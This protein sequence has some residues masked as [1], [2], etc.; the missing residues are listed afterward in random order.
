MEDA[1]AFV[2]VAR[3]IRPVGIKG[4]LRVMPYTRDPEEL[5]KYKSLYFIHSD[6]P[7]HKLKILNIRISS[8]YAT[9]KVEGLDSIEEAESWRGRELYVQRKQLNKPPIDEYFIRDLI[10]IE[11]YGE[12]GI[13]IGRLKDVMEFS[14]H[15]I[16]QIE[17]QTGELLI[18]AISDVVLTI[19]LDQNKMIVRL[20]DGLQD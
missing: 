19:D 4:E 20:L 9:I 7:P 18:P 2:E 1:N 14:H 6:E 12:D 10:G 3:V 8:G 13:L 11:V 17:T 16:Y 5:G 15:D